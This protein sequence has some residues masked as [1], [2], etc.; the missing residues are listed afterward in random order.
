LQR[1]RLEQ[2]SYTLFELRVS[3]HGDEWIAP[4]CCDSEFVSTL[5]AAQRKINFQ[6]RC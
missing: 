4:N 3:T 5:G 6:M 2:H 1:K